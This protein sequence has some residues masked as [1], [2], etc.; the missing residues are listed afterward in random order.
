MDPCRCTKRPFYLEAGYVYWD[1]SA[2]G[3]SLK[4]SVDSAIDCVRAQALGMVSQLPEDDMYSVSRIQLL[5]KLDICM[6][7]V[8]AEEL[9]FGRDHTTAGMRMPVRLHV[10]SVVC[11]PLGVNVMVRRFQ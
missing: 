4:R 9:V 3:T 2:A 7:G 5:A 8:V 6:A 10:H 11:S 1:I